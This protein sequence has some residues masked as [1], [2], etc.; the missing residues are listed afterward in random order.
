MTFPTMLAADKRQATS[1]G[2]GLTRRGK[3]RPMWPAS[4]EDTCAID[5]PRRMPRVLGSS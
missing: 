4:Q 3:G 5:A 1:T 2:R